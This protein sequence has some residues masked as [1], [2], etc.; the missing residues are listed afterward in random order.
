LTSFVA[1]AEKRLDEDL[2]VLTSTLADDKKLEYLQRAQKLRGYTT[3]A[4]I[5]AYINLDDAIGRWFTRNKTKLGAWAS[6]LRAN[7]TMEYVGVSHEELMRGSPAGSKRPAGTGTILDAIKGLHPAR[8]TS[9]AGCPA[10]PKSLA[11]KYNE[12]V[13]KRKA[14]KQKSKGR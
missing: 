12:E 5:N 2:A 14:Q 10:M 1:W 8:L 4:Y 7:Y 11:E 3:G 6:C 9:T 13:E